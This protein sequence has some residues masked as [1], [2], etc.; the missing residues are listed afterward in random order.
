MFKS[1]ISKQI[2]NIVSRLKLPEIR[3]GRTLDDCSVSFLHAD[4][5]RK[6]PF[7]K[8]LYVDFYTELAEALPEEKN[9]GLIVELGSGAGFIKEV[10]PLILTSDVLRLP[11]IN[12]NFSA[13]NMP[14]HDSTVGALLMINTLHHIGNTQAFLK[15]ANRCLKIG[16]RI[17][18]IEPAN[19]IFSSFGYR[20]FH[21]EDFDL[22]GEWSFEK[23]SHIFSANCAIAWIIFCRDR[24]RF[25]REF[26]S[27]KILKIKVH[28]PFR[29]WISGG[30]S[31]LQLVPC[32]AYTIIKS[33]EKLLSPLDRYI[34][35]FMTIV[36]EKVP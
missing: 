30:F 4:I 20:N 32:W 15:E 5:I 29:Y 18:M 33:I 14:F 1:A 12:L 34:G 22:S 35:M 21:Y 6:K 23:K 10:I 28:T 7:L 17:V 11:H 31:V 2:E 27:L 25:E 3:N 8:K 13:L 26:P 24:Q 9:G 16:G 19:T 36:L